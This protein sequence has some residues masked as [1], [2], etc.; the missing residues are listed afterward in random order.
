MSQQLQAFVAANQ[1]LPVTLIAQRL[2]AARA[3]T[4]DLQNQLSAVT[5]ANQQKQAQNK[6]LT[7]QLQL[8]ETSRKLNLAALEKQYNDLVAAI[9]LKRSE[10]E[11]ISQ[12][13]VDSRARNETLGY[14]RRITNEN[15]QDPKWLA[16]FA[17]NEG[18]YKMILNQFVRQMKDFQRFQLGP[19]LAYYDTTA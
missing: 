17:K 13:V 14:S 2:E 3:K 16:E 1:S 8:Q 10:Y 11:T 9:A 18:T 6:A 5:R 12:R 7:E 15:L 19:M 4:L